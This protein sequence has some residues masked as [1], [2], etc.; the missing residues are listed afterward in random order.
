MTIR[1]FR[2]LLENNT[3]LWLEGYDEQSDSA[4][5]LRINN[6]LLG[7]EAFATIRIIPSSVYVKENRIYIKTDMPFSVFVSWIN[8]SLKNDFWKSV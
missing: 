5:Y 4:S 7:C 2:N 8:Y 3:E 1:E 6:L